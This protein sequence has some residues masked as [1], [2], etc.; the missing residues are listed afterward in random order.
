MSAKRTFQH[1]REE[2]GES[3]SDLADALGITLQQITQWEFGQTEPT[4]SRLRVLPERFGVRDDEI[5]PWPGHPPT[6]A[7]RLTDLF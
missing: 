4:S 3:R 5:D 2:R 6:I 1:R 7:E